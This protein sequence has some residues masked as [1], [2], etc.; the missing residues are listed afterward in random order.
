MLDTTCNQSVTVYWWIVVFWSYHNHR[1]HCA[2]KTIIS[3]IH[4]CIITYLSTFWDTGF[5]NII[6]ERAYAVWPV[7]AATSSKDVLHSVESPSMVDP[8]W[9]IWYWGS[10]W[11]LHTVCWGAVGCEWGTTSVYFGITYVCFIP[12]RLPVLAVEPKY[13][14]QDFLVL[15]NVLFEGHIQ[16]L[17]KNH[18]GLKFE[19]GL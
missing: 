17:Q 13:R 19:W 1:V 6:I 8:Q 18:V 16:N 5:N 11:N 12:S 10:K 15:L 3:Y 9:N 7:V 4:G 2:Q 14:L